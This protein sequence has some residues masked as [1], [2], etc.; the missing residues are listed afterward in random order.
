MTEKEKTTRKK[1][2]KETEGGR[3]ESKMPFVDHLEELRRRLFY[4]VGSIIGL[5]L[6]AYIFS[7][8]LLDIITMPVPEGTS[9]IS[10]AP[11]QMFIVHIKVSFYAGIILGMPVL[12]FQF[13]QFVAPG[14]FP[15]ERK[16]L[17]PVIFFTVFSF[18]VGGLFAYFIVVPNGLLFLQSFQ[19]EDIIASWSIDKYISFVTM[20]IMVFG[21]VFEIPLLAVFLAKIGLIDHRMM[22]KYRK[23]SIL[24]AVILGAILTP[25]DGFTQIALA[26]PLWI[27]YEIS[28]FLVRIFGSGD[29]TED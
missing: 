17:F 24:G 21:V 13:W 8:R 1:P 9:L 18:V 27:L 15:K 19:T 2:E 4:C 14:L 29:E 16:A 7:Q 6:I 10:L 12:V 5:G 22:R 20:M 25:P 3:N 26:V 11:Q 23:Y 28:I